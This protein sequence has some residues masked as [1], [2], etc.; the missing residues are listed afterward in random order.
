MHAVRSAFSA[1][2]AILVMTFR[3]T[4][5]QMIWRIAATAELLILQTVRFFSNISHI[6]DIIFAFV[7]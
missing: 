5:S 2:T 4:L 3:E 7:A 1:A 6:R